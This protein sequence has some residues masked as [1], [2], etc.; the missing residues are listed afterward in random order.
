VAFTKKSPRPQRARGGVLSGAY[1]VILIL[2]QIIDKFCKLGMSE[3]KR[4]LDRNRMA[5]E[6]TA[7][8]KEFIGP[9]HCYPR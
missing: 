2:N 9:G 7:N 8:V 6:Q 4:K 1:Q 5:D 3:L